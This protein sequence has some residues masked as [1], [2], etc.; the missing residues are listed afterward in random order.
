MLTVIGRHLHRMTLLAG[1]DFMGLDGEIG[2]LHRLG[3]I[4]LQA[5][6][7]SRPGANEQQG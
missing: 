6:E 1:I 7:P 4:H 2:E 3:R 5:G